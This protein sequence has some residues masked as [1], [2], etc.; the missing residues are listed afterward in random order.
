MR[1]R[2]SHTSQ[3]LWLSMC[4]FV[5]CSES[6][7]H[8]SAVEKVQDRMSAYGLFSYMIWSDISICTEKPTDSQA[9]LPHWTEDRKKE[10]SY[11]HAASCWMTRSNF[12]LFLDSMFLHSAFSALTLLVGHHEEH[13]SVKIEWWGV[14]VVICL[15]Q[16]ADC[17]N[18][19]QLMPL[20]SQNPVTSC[21]VFNPDWFDLSG[22]GLPRLLWKRGC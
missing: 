16:G 11:D 15:E 12:H 13:P 10:K 1:T 20:P 9:N 6:A 19:V 3:Q 22:T 2:H 21:L 17:L 8:A 4:C 7:A 5:F 14:S 18:M